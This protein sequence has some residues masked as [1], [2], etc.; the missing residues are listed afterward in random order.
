MVC[1]NLTKPIQFNYSIT[2][3][4]AEKRLLDVASALGIAT[5]INRPF[6]EGRLFSKVKGKPL[7][8]WAADYDITTWSVY[9]LKY[10][11]AHPAV[12]CAIPATANPQH[13]H[14]NVMAAKGELLS[15]KVKKKMVNYLDD[16]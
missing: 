12:T 2:A 6:G 11:I 9:F 15:D 13:A 3:R 4:N 5:L 1:F 10:I 14:D 7:P 16:L 8:P